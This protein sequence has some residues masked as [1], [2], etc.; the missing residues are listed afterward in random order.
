MRLS[1]AGRLNC[2]LQVP[3]ASPRD[4][5][6][7]RAGAGV[8]VAVAACR[9]PTCAGAV[10]GAAYSSGEVRPSRFV[11]SVKKTALAQKRWSDGPPSFVVW[12]FV[13]MMLV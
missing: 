12:W 2:G 3:D 1:H 11:G 13:I 5:L 6:P 8:G 9:S 4:G 7:G 10:A